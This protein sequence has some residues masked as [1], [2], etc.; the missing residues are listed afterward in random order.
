MS[1]SEPT[2]IE[3]IL[4]RIPRADFLVTAR[5]EDRRSGMLL[6]WVQTCSESPVMLA[7]AVPKSCSIL[8]LMS[9]SGWFG[10]CM[11]AEEDRIIARK[12]HNSETLADD[13]FL[14]LQIANGP[15]SLVPLP[16]MC[17]VAIEC[18]VVCHVDVEGDH[19]LFI[20]QVTFAKI[21]GRPPTLHIPIPWEALPTD[22]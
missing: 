7:A 5:T 8:P 1:K 14:G 9:E 6:R 22:K 4:E 10:L 20:G 15:N 11:L 12:F 17:S 16:V 19:E 13:P 21:N 3:S 2:K 18:R